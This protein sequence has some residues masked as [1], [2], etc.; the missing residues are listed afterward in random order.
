VIDALTSAASGM[1]QDVSRLTT[2]GQNLANAAT[3]GYKRAMETGAAFSLLGQGLATASHTVTDLRHASLQSTSAP[4]DVAIDGE[5]F[6]EV[7][8]EAGAAYTRRGDFRLD[9]SGRLVT[10][11][12]HVVQGVGGSLTLATSSPTIDRAGRV[13]DGD[14]LLGQLKI[15]DFADA[16]QLTRQEDGLFVTSQSP[17]VQAEGATR[18][19]QGQLEGSNVSTAAE[20]VRLIETVRHFEATQKVIQG[21]DEMSERALRKLGEF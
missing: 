12:G 20:M 3:P 14:K 19:R 10:Q 1:A 6:F 16:R 17:V 4:L 9:A 8:T 21:V 2:I 13:Y 15:V 18:L 5:G 11:A 7:Q